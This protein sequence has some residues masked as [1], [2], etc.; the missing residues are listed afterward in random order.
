[1]FAG[2]KGEELDGGTDKRFA[3]KVSKITVK[4]HRAGDRGKGGEVMLL[5]SSE[6]LDRGP[7]MKTQRRIY[8]KRDALARLLPHVHGCLPSTRSGFM[9]GLLVSW[10]VVVNFFVGLDKRD[11]FPL[12]LVSNAPIPCD[13]MR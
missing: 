10:A 13:A 7:W 2:R 3:E 6:T 1:M 9:A 12:R 4:K 5:R 8:E 11:F